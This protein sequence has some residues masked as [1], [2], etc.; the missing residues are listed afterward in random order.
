MIGLFCNSYYT[1]AVEKR[2]NTYLFQKT[3]PKNQRYGN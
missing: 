2:K 3:Y 1:A